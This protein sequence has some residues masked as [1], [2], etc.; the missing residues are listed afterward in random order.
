MSEQERTLSEEFRTYS[1]LRTPLEWLTNLPS[2]AHAKTVSRSKPCS[3][4]SAVPQGLVVVGPNSNWASSLIIELNDSCLTR[5]SD[6][7]I[8]LSAVS[9]AALLYDLRPHSLY[10]MA[11]LAELTDWLRSD[12]TYADPS[13]CLNTCIMGGLGHTAPA[14]RNR[15]HMQNC[16]R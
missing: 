13:P 11:I 12:K 4:H 9:R 16:E 7:K 14:P 6:S 10:T 5:L 3:L 8:V 15:H 2:W 1:Q